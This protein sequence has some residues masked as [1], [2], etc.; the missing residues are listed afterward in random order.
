VPEA[1]TVKRRNAIE[2]AMRKRLERSRHSRLARETAK[3][4]KTEEQTL[5]NEECAGESQWP[6]Y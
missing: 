2:T 5:A 1:V 3:L 6:E 4:D